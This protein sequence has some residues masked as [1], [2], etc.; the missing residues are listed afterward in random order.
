MTNKTMNPFTGF[1]S[2]LI[3]MLFIITGYALPAFAGSN[4]ALTSPD[5]INYPP[6]QFNLL[7]V[8]RVVLEN[9]IVLYILEDHEL[10]LVNVNA[11]IKTGTMYD[12]KG[13]EGVAE[14]TAYVM[15]TGG[16]AKLNSAQI[17]SQLDFMAASA[18]IAMAMESAHVNFSILNNDL[19]HGLDLLAQILMYPAFEQEKFELAKRLKNEE[20]RRLKDDPQKL[21]FR[22]FYRLIYLNDPRGGYPTTKSVAGI[23]RDDLIK[24][25]D[26]FFMPGNIIFSISGDI[27]KEEAVKKFNRYFGGW[28]AGDM[29]A[30]VLPPPQKSNAGVYFIDKEIAQSTLI[31][32]RFAPSKNDPDFYALPFLILLSAAA[33][34]LPEL[35]ALCEIMKVWLTAQGAS[36]APDPNTGFSALMP[37]RNHPQ[38]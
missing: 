29:A 33:V 4:S 18:S 7:P 13:Q 20:L 16:T 19:D 6:L 3:L 38:P 8:Q 32:G 24:F 2:F 27:T 37:L 5:K 17:D 21:A 11:L 30:A 9:G 34:S 22:E 12:P 31:S 15:R 28:K 10:P 35:S 1:F 25:H 26:R 23:E 14:L 36:I